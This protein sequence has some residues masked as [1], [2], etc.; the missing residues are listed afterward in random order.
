M[1]K[2]LKIYNEDGNIN[3]E[4]VDFCHKNFVIQNLKKELM[5][6]FSP[7]CSNLINLLN[8]INDVFGEFFKDKVY[9]EI[10][11]YGDYKDYRDEIPLSVICNICMVRIVD[12]FNLIRMR[13]Y[14][15]CIDQMYCKESIDDKQY[16]NEKQRIHG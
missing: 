5:R 11:Q 3:E 16:D 13:L 2:K 15:Y 12:N 7:I 9:S 6:E 14:G 1:G 10:R 8:I 4:I